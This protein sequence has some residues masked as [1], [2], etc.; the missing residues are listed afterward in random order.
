MPY[1]HGHPWPAGAGGCFYYWRAMSFF[2]EFKVRLAFVV[3]L[4]ASLLALWLIFM[5]FLH[6]RRFRSGGPAQ[7]PR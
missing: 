6:M 5:I 3:V 7:M 4:P 1:P 2:K